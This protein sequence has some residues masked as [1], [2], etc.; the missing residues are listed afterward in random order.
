MHLFGLDHTRVTYKRN[1]LPQ[2]LTDGQDGKV[3]KELLA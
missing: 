2:T 3:V 1:N